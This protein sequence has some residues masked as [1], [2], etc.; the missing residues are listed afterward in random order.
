MYGQDAVSIS[1]KEPHISLRNNRS[2]FSDAVFASDFI[3][4]TTTNNEN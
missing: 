4:L 3:E 1:S 2:V